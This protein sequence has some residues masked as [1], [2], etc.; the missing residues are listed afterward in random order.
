MK[1]LIIITLLLFAGWQMQAQSDEIPE[2]LLQMEREVAEGNMPDEQRLMFYE[3]LMYEYFTRDMEKVRYYFQKATAFACEK[4]PDA[5]Q[6]FYARMGIIF[7]DL[8]ERDSATIYL[9]IA[10]QLLENVENDYEKANIYDIMGGHYADYN[11]HENAINAYLICLDMNEKDKTRKIAENNDISRNIMFEA[12]TR[13][14]IA[15]V[16]GCSIMKNLWKSCFT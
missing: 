15:Y 1:R 6:R 4:K 13:I 5:E 12:K 14:N 3:W 7:S 11:D 8:K 16:E 2:R 9:D 10:V